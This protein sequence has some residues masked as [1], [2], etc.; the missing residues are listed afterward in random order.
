MEEILDRDDRKRRMFI[1]LFVGLGM[2]LLFYGIY[3]F[4]QKKNNSKEL[5]TSE[6]ASGIG[7]MNPF[8]NL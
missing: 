4:Y 5:S 8:V 1:W 2:I 3:A 6:V 7:W